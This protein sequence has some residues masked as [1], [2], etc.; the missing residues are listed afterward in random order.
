MAW[1][2]H[3]QSQFCPVS[4]WRWAG[5]GRAIVSSQHHFKEQLTMYAE[6]FWDWK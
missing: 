2:L 4:A 1:L 6:L 5:E 3:V